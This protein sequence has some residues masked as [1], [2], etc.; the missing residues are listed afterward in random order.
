IG[1]PPP[2]GGHFSFTV[3][4]NPGVTMDLTALSFSLGY[5][6]LFPGNPTDFIAMW[7]VGGVFTPIP[8]LGPAPLPPTAFGGFSGFATPLGVL[9]FSGTLE[10]RIFP[11]GG[12]GTALV[13]IDNIHLEGDTFSNM[14]SV[15]EPGSASL[16]ASALVLIGLV[17][18]RR[19]TA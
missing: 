13:D 8:G 17:R 4:T 12:T 9:G 3:T 19:K 6:S 5:A 2:T 1:P 7:D 18:F 11:Y 14:G 16:L 10:I 15:P